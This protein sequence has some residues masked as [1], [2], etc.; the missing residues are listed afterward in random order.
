MGKKNK[1]KNKRNLYRTNISLEF[2]ADGYINPELLLEVMHEKLMEH[3]EYENGMRS[4]ASC[5]IVTAKSTKKEVNS[6]LEAQGWGVKVK[7]VF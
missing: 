5:G 2:Y 3:V 7:D 1:N 6:F 4:V